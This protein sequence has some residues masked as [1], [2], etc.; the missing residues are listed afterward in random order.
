L[1]ARDAKIRLPPIDE[2]HRIAAILDK[3]DA[4]RRKRRRALELQGKLF[5]SIFADMFED[6]ASSKKPRSSLEDFAKIQV[7]FAFKSSEYTDRPDGVRLCRG[8]NILPSKIDWSDLARW[9]KE[10]AAE[11]RDYYLE[12]GDVVIAMDRPWIS[13]GFKVARI[14][15]ADLPSLLVQRVARLRPKTKVDGDFLFA[16]VHSPLFS[17]HFKPTETTVP[18]ISPTE[19]RKFTF[20]VPELKQREKFS[21]L[22]RQINALCDSGNADLGRLVLGI[23]AE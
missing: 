15:A 13:S 14:A 9:P 6:F 8:A 5:H 2:Q 7:G 4:L 11:F 22:S 21:A 10:R 23:R 18:H 3:A 17:S 16:L 1:Y 19:I 20:A 12:S